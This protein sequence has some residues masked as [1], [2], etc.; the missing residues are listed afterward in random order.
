MTSQYLTD[1]AILDY[2]H[3]SIQKLIDQRGWRDLTSQQAVK[4]VYYFVRDEIKFGYNR[5][6]SIAASEVLAD[7]YGQCNTKST[8]FMAL[9]RALGI[10]C[11]FHGFT[12]HNALQRGAIPDYIMRIAPKR[13]LHSWPE[14]LLD[15][16]WLNMEGLIIDQA[17]L[18]QIQNAFPNSN[19]FSGYGIAVPCLQ[20][21]DNE[22]NGNSTYIQADGI[23]DD[24]GL[25]DNPDEFY[26]KYG[27]NLQGLKKLAYRYVLRHLI[28]RNVERIRRHGLA[29]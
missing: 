1:T 12:I 9:L 29:A 17:F 7:G 3:A 4:E 11:R 28:N 5:D 23:A 14:V 24:F 2:Q 25:F 10:P 22:F 19:N 13:I 15:G 21:P 6:D 26:A 20:K 27:R 18:A 8:L 16:E